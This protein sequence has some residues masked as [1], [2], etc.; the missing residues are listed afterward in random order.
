MED[1]PWTIWTPREPRPFNNPEV[2]WR[3]K[4]IPKD[5]GTTLRTYIKSFSLLEA[6][7]DIAPFSVTFRGGLNL[8]VGENGSGKS[9]MLHLMSNPEESKKIKKLELNSAGFD[10]KFYDTEKNNPRIKSNFDNSKNIGLDLYSRFI[11]HGE[12]MLPII[13]ASRSFKDLLLII[14]EPEAGISLS[15]QKKILEALVTA[16]E[17]GCQV[18]ISTHSYVLINSV[19]DVF[20]MGSKTWMSSK[21]YLSKIL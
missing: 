13:T 3:G 21:E 15:N 17:N 20:D 14:D 10:F 7:R 18:I 2:D 9:S 12:T 1:E 6:Y 19:Q 16:V 5:K 11:S 8:I 4:P